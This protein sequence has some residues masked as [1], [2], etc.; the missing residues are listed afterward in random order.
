MVFHNGLYF[1]E[2]GK[3]TDFYK[4][5]IAREKLSKSINTHRAGSDPEFSRGGGAK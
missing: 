1:A 2:V 4:F 5:I 3:S